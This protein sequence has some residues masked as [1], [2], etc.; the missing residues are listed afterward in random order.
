MS[1]ERKRDSV[2]VREREKWE[3]GHVRERWGGERVRR[4]DK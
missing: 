4:G 1:R 3:I 2:C